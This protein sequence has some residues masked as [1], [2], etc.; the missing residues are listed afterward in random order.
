VGISEAVLRLVVETHDLESVKH[1]LEYTLFEAQKGKIKE[2]IDG[3]FISAVKGKFTNAAFEKEK[4]KRVGEGQAHNKREEK[5]ALKKQIDQLQ[6]TLFEK[7]NAIIKEIIAQDASVTPLAIEQAIKTVQQTPQLI[8][9]VKKQGLTLEN[10][11]LAGWRKDKILRGCVIEAIVS[12]HK[13]QFSHLTLEYDVLRGLQQK[14]AA[15]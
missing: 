6:D 5:N 10:L 14:A 12:Q 11:D 3:Y 1:G 7:Q 9:Y 4:N 13:K 8:N 2:S 15:L